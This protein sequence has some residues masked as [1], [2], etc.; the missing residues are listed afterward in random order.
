MT[1]FIPSLIYAI[2]SMSDIVPDM[3]GSMLSKIDTVT[4]LSGLILQ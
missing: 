4:L 1:S 2:H 3:E